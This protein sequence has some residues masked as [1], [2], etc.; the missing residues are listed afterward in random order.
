MIRVNNDLAKLGLQEYDVVVHWN[1][2]KDCCT[3]SSVDF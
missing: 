2:K 1:G 3:Q